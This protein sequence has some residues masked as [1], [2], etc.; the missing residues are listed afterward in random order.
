M[1]FI[2]T[3]AMFLL[4]GLI[5]ILAI[6][7]VFTSV[8]LSVTMLEKKNQLAEAAGKAAAVNAQ[9]DGKPAVVEN[10]KKAEKYPIYFNGSGGDMHYYYFNEETAL[11]PLDSIL[12]SLNTG[13][14]LINSDDVYQARL[15]GKQI[16]LTLGRPEATFSNERIQLRSAAVTADNHVLVSPEI[17]A[18]PGGFRINGDNGKDGVFIDYWPA[19][20]SRDFAKTGLLSLVY[21]LPRVN[22]LSGENNF[23]YAKSGPGYTSGIKYSAA[24]S[25]YIL[26]SNGSTW[27]IN[28]KNYKKPLLLNAGKNHKTSSDG[29]FLYWQDEDGKALYILDAGSNKTTRVKNYLSLF[30]GEGKTPED[31]RLSGFQAGRRYVRLDFEEYGRNTVYTV[32]ERDR[33]IVAQ[34]T[35]WYSPDRKRIIFYNS[36]KGYF[37]IDQDGT[38]AISL[39]AVSKAQWVDNSRIFLYSD[40]GMSIFN[41]GSRKAQVTDLPEKYVGKTLKGEILFQKADTLFYS[42][43]AGVQKEL[44]RLPWV[45]DHIFAASIKGP[46][47]AMSLKEDSLL[48]IYGSRQL[49]LGEPGL[50]FNTSPSFS[51]EALFQANTAISPDNKKAAFLQKGETFLEINI[52]GLTDMSLERVVLDYP[53]KNN[54]GSLMKIKWLNNSSLLIYNDRL[55][56]Q[57]DVRK[58]TS[59]RKWTNKEEE[60]TIGDLQIY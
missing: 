34:G 10:I 1:K 40:N 5:V 51:P 46:F 23:S 59:I 21:G 11:I 27:L 12:K 55:G 4:I 42:N 36:E 54:S 17:L 28:S 2:K 37:V 13:G 41:R 52:T 30:T 53:L 31:Y 3:R 18:L 14:R 8:R 35:A 26:E 38:D 48:G 15:A 29:R 20:Y 25:S 33:K 16:Y 19:A 39:G 6:F 50:F 49:S 7:A 45:S 47:Y 32:L 22:D 58:G 43:A 44:F 60:V 56:W 24:L 9:Q 57:V